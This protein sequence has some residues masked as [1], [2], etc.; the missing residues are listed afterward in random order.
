MASTNAYIKNTGARTGA[1]DD[2]PHLGGVIKFV[3]N[4]SSN[5]ATSVTV[6]AY[7]YLGFGS[8]ADSSLSYTQYA[9]AVR[10]W[11]GATTYAN[12]SSSTKV[13]KTIN[14]SGTT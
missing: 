6:T 4:R 7:Y 11:S 5:T 2:G 3:C 1:F 14:S 12:A 8:Y 10:A 13:T 9:V